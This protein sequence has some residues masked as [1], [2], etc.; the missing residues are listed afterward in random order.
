MKIKHNWHVSNNQMS[1]PISERVSATWITVNCS[2]FFLKSSFYTWLKL[3]SFLG[4]NGCKQQK[5]QKQIRAS[6]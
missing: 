2:C 1:K 4:K 3:E 6:L 5:Y